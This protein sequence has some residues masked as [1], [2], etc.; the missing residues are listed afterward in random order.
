[1]SLWWLLS[2][3]ALAVPA[4]E[5]VGLFKDRAMLRIDGEDR[6]LRV[7]DTS[8]EGVTLI[9]AD[10][11]RVV[12]EYEGEEIELNLSNRIASSFQVPSKNQLSIPSDPMGQYWVRGFIGGHPVNF[13]VDTGASVIAMSSVEATRLGIDFLTEGQVGM[14]QTAQGEAVSHFVNI[15]AV[16]VGGIEVR[17]VRAAIVEGSYPRNILLGMSYLRHV[18]IEQREGI[19][20]LRE[21]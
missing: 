1:M 4:V 15:P 13:L 2:A 8:R 5:V 12:L 19:L 18:D 9:Y 20:M 21:K 10:T 6:F 14:A 17:D 16:E 7:G 11:Q 3:A